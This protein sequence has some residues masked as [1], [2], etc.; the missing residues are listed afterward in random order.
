MQYIYGFD[1]N[2]IPFW[3]KA[4]YWGLYML[5]FVYAIRKTSSLVTKDEEPRDV[6]IWFGVFFALY[7]V[8]YCI[9]DDY[10]S[11]RQWIDGRDFSWWTK[12]YFY[13]YVILFCR[14]LPFDYPFEV[15]RLIV[16][17]GAIFIAYQTYRLYEELLL[18]G[19][20]LLL[21]FVFHAGVF[22]YARASLAIAVYSLGIALYL[23]HNG[24]IWKLLGIAVAFSSYFFHHELLIGIAVLPCLFIPLER[25]DFSCL[26]IFLLLFAIVAISFFSS[27]LDYL[28][29]LFDN[30]DITSKIEDYN[31]KEQGVFRLSTFIRYL[32][33]FVP[34]CLLTISFWKKGAPYPVIGM[35]R[36]T[37]GIMMASVAFMVIFGLRSVYVYRTMYITTIP[38]SLLIGYGYCQGYFT[39]KQFLIMIAL[40]L[41]SSSTSIINAL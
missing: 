25:R 27:N 26:S 4:L 6:T 21:L 38:T 8:F 15:F 36:I 34:F 33:F 5:A 10:F 14:S 2:T 30:D 9:N 18:P 39:K 17:G 13:V 24:M 29:A 37:Y 19:L 1:E 7:A 35:Y 22:C 11:Y 20:T 31:E 32:K 28:D 3:I 12:E 23:F 16:W 40:A 41:L